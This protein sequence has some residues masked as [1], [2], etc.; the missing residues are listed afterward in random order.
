MLSAR[1]TN[2]TTSQADLGITLSGTTSYYNSSPLTEF[3]FNAKRDSN[4]VIDV[5]G[6]EIDVGV[7]YI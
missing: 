7:Y 1:F 2:G 3:K 5:R 6:Y 4:V